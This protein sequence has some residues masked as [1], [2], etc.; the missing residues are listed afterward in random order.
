MTAPPPTRRR[1][2]AARDAAGTPGA[3]ACRPERRRSAVGADDLAG[4]EDLFEAAQVVVEL[5]VGLLAEVLGHGPAERSS[6]DVVAEG[7]ADLGAAVSGG[8][9]EQHLTGVLDVGV[10]YRAPGD[11]FGGLVER[12]LGVPLH[13]LTEWCAGSPVAAAGAGLADFVQVHHEGR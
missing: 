9:H 10:T 12:G 6:R 1:R 11:P 2:G 13:G 3:P 5:L 7:H 4:F 8:R